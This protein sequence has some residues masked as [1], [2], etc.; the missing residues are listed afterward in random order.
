M[1]SNS[2]RSI[3]TALVGIT[4]N[5]K[6]PLEKDRLRMELVNAMAIHLDW[7]IERLPSDPRYKKAFDDNLYNKSFE[8]AWVMGQLK[9]VHALPHLFQAIKNNRYHPTV[10]ENA[11]NALGEI[12]DEQALPHLMELINKHDYNLHFA[13]GALVKIGNTSAVPPLLDSLENPAGDDTQ[14]SLIWALGQLHDPRAAPTLIEWVKTHTADM[15]AVAIQALGSLGDP[16]AI[17]IL[18]S[19]LKDSTR[20]HRQDMGGTFWLFRTYREKRICDLAFEA[21]Q[22]IGTP[23]ALAIIQKW[24]P[25]VANKNS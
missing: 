15:Q 23:E 17:P 10:R 13:I 6:D 21:L 25:P 20:L 22:R 11:L 19:C 9:S 14:A 12:G 24:P 8:A 1:E 5:E 4:E 18:E 3:S 2:L 16:Q 7:Q